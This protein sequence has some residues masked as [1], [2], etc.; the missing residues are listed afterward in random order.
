MDTDAGLPFE[1]GVRPEDYPKSG[2]RPFQTPWGEYALHAHAGRFVA[3][4]AWCPHMRGPLWEGTRHEEELVCPWHG[5][6][7]SLEGGHCTWTPAGAGESCE[8]G[9][10]ALLQVVTGPAGTLHILPPPQA[11]ESR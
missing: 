10:L 8:G 1:T 6:R 7:Y 5:W 2:P 4:P 11:S 9:S 3:A